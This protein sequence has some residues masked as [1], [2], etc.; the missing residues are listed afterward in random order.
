MTSVH[1]T[2]TVGK[3]AAASETP[4][5]RRFAFIM[6]GAAGGGRARAIWKHHHPNSYR[7]AMTEHARH[8]TELARELIEEGKWICYTTLVAIGGDGTISQVVNGY[9]Q[10]DG[11]AHGVSL[12]VMSGGTGG[13]FVRTL[14]I[15][16]LTPE[17]AWMA[18]EHGEIRDVDVG[19]VQFMPRPEL[20]LLASNQESFVN[21]AQETD[22][23]DD[24][25]S[26]SHKGLSQLY[27][28][29]ICSV[30]MR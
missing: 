22:D 7:L 26:K 8:A 28:I 19:L 25:F 16:R 27:F 12:A 6:N 21:A 23:D 29:N 2:S 30:G 10:A 1:T 9:M 5:E 14:G 15:D 13:D 20:A 17:E 3:D 18:L 24:S 4:G 11:K